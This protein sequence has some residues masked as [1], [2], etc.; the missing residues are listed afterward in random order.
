MRPPSWSLTCRGSGVKYGLKQQGV[1]Y[2]AGEGLVLDPPQ[3]EPCSALKL[4]LWWWNLGAE[5][6]LPLFQVGP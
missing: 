4:S 5:E 1:S 6:T 3:A 2:G